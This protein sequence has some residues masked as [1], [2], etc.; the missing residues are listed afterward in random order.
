M[1][2]NDIQ[3]RDDVYKLVVRFYAQVRR[4]ELLGPIFNGIITDWDHHQ[5]KI[6]DFW[7]RNLLQTG[8][9]VGNPG[10]KHMDVDEHENNT[11]SPEHFERWLSIWRATIDKLFVG[12]ISDE[13]KIKAERIGANFMKMILANRQAKGSPSP[14][15]KPGQRFTLG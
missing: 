6:S 2:K 11:I 5:H 9:F 1:E 14:G 3:T 12:P 7:E 10:R 15:F 8:N 4:D 13:A